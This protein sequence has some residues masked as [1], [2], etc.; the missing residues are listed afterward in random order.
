MGTTGHSRVRQMG[1]MIAMIAAALLSAACSPTS[2]VNQTPA[3]SGAPV[4]ILASPLT[5]D[6]YQEGVGV[7]ILVRVENAGPDVA[8]VAIS[9]DGQIIGEAPLPNPDG[10]ASFTVRNG[11]PATG[12]GTHIISAVASRSDGTV[13]QPA[14][15]QINVVGAPTQ[16]QPTA[17]P[18]NTQAAA[19]Q[20][21]TSTDAGGQSAQPTNPPAQPT[22]PPAQ[23][24]NPPAEPTNPPAPTATPTVGRPEVRVISG[25]NV[26]SG[27][28][29]VF[30]PPIGSLAAGS[31]APIL[32]VHTGGAWYKIQYY[33]GEAWIFSQVVEVVGDVASLPRDAGPATPI[34]VTPT[35]APTATV[36]T[37]VD[38]IIDGAK[39]SISAQ[40]CNVAAEARITVVNAGTSPSAA[41]NVVWEDLFNGASQGS[42]SAPVP[43]LQPGQSTLVVM[44]LTVSTNY[45]QT[46]TARVTVDPTNAVPETNDGNNAFTKD[47]TL[48]RG[49]CP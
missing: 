7:N 35:A 27:P 34:P 11:W 20:P 16:S 33:N 19:E 47:Y 48:A 15:V 26:R 46:H 36:A 28:G 39:S 23:P 24:T 31:T 29:V 37:A 49:T 44:Y 3:F 9:V 13:S 6:T 4:V 43:A 25:A 21:T 12:A 1:L 5:N 41:A 2:T 22:N 42:T 18:T 30:D 32:A 14:Q 8:R 17:A 45:N 40:V 38:L 10:A